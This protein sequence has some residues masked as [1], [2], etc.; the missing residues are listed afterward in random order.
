ML[1]Y[2]KHLLQYFQ[3]P[4]SDPY[5]FFFFCLVF[6]IGV[7]TQGL[8][9]VFS[10]ESDVAAAAVDVGR[11]LFRRFYP[12]DLDRRY[13]CNIWAC[14]PTVIIYFNFCHF[15]F[16]HIRRELSVVSYSFLVVYFFMW[17]DYLFFKLKRLESLKF[18]V[19]PNRL[20]IMK[21]FSTVMLIMKPF[22]NPVYFDKGL[23]AR[24]FIR[25]V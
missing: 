3:N 13:C 16:V 21:W 23:I 9:N 2:F 20:L 14:C 5:L 4:G 11:K 24:Y 6:F 25:R 18:D 15:S 22:V 19:R 10:F 8:L 1:R 12:C 7:Q 17:M